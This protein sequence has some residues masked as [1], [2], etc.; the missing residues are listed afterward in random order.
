M[1]VHRL[2]DDV[3]VKSFLEELEEVASESHI[4]GKCTVRELLE[5]MPPE[6]AEAFSVALASGYKGTHIAKAM[7]NRKYNISS[8]TIQRHRRGGC[9]CPPVD[10][11]D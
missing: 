7:K 6:D 2:S 11:E 4:G 10:K 1:E 5:T 9:S 3:K 8:Y